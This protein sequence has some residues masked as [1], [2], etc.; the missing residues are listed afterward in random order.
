MA[1]QNLSFKYNLFSAT[2]EELISPNGKLSRFNTNMNYI[3]YLSCNNIII[4][5]L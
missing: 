2:D 4:S 3:N 5:K 1:A